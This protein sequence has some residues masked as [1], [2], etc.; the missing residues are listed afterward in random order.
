[1]DPAWD[2]LTLHARSV[3]ADPKVPVIGSRS[4]P[5]ATIVNAGIHYTSD[6]DLIDGD[7]GEHAS[8]LPQYLRNIQGSY[9]RTRRYSIG[10]SWAVDW[11]GGV[12]E[13]RGWTY[14]P[15]AHAGANDTAFAVLMLVDGADPATAE[16][17]ASARAIAREF[18][19]RAG[20]ALAGIYGH[21]ELPG[22]T[23][24]TGCC[25]AG[26]YRQ[27]KA[28]PGLHGGLFSPRYQPPAPAIP[29][30][31]EE[32]DDMVKLIVYVK[33]DKLRAEALVL[34]DGGGTEMIGFASADDRNAMVGALGVQPMAVSAAQYDD[35]VMHALAPR[36]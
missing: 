3:W 17:L 25:G 14:Q 20:R 22:R 8:G 26:L 23:T 5:W 6:D 11:L 16:A 12:W 34:I 18:E 31:P 2:D 33:D 27:L 13:L 36:K 9:V 24:P 7:P 1:M 32:D 29:N 15:A 30:D 21:N 10:Y 28:V 19:R 4:F 35:F